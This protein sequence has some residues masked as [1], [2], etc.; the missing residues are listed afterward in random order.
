MVRIV[1]E[2]TYG[3]VTKPSLKCDTPQDYK[4]RV[5]KLMTREDAINEMAEMEYLLKIKNIEKYVLRLPK[6]CNPLDSKEFHKALEKCQ[7]PRILRASKENPKGFRLLLLDDGGVDLTKFVKKNILK[8]LSPNDINIFFTSILQLFEGVSFF[9]DN[10]IIHHDIKLPNIV[11][12][13]KNSKIK[14]IDFGIMTKRSTFIRT[15]SENRNEIAQSW[16]YFPKEFSCVNKGDFDKMWKC[17]NY[18]NKPYDQFVKKAA[19][20]FDSYC[21]SFGLKDLFSK[22]VGKIS[23]IHNDFFQKSKLLMEEYCDSDIFKRSDDLMALYSRYKTLLKKYNIYNTSNPTPSSKSIELAE[24]YS[25]N[26]MNKK[27]EKSREESRPSSTKNKTRKT[28]VIDLR[29]PTKTK[30]SRQNTLRQSR[31]NNSISKKIHEPC[32]PGKE[33]NPKTGRCINVKKRVNIME[34]PCPPGKVRNPKTKRCVTQ[35]KTDEE[36]MREPCPPGKIRNP[37]TRRCVKTQ[38]KR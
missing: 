22:L 33:R 21:L 15:S 38:K 14:F 35:K 4:D 17:S 7:S 12:N 25:I 3:C 23:H 5:S 19:D 26:K 1:G 36:K 6:L 16:S 11:Y 13:V 31:K 2:G 37:K 29:T 24:K 28:Q 34:K 32:P 27:E 18:R 30:Q 9:R 20:T 8:S 10:D